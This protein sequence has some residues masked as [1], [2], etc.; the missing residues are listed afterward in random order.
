[1][2]KSDYKVGYK[3]PPKKTQY[4]AGDRGNPHGRPK[5]TKNLKT[6]LAEELAETITVRENGRTQKMSKQRALVKGVVARAMSGD[7]RAA[8]NVFSLA[9]KLLIDEIAN[10]ESAEVDPKDKEIF[11]DFVRRYAER[12]M[13]GSP[14]K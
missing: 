3:K 5:G 4:K 7:H 10:D 11:D 1:M 14:G 13:K 9:M 6:D 8:T 12:R 2:A